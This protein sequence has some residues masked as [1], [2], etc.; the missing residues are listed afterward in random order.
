MLTMGIKQRFNSIGCPNCPFLDLKGSPEAIDSCTSGSFEGTMAILSPG[1]SWVA[2][3]FRIDNLVM[4]TYA[5]KVDG[6]LPEDVK[7]MLEE[8]DII[9][10]P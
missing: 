8:M 7:Q 2:R 10:F 4:G 6:T 9:W 1:R 3:W 5:M